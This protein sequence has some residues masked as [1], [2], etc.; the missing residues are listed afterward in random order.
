MSRKWLLLGVS[1]SI[2]LLATHCQADWPRFRGPNGSG[3]SADSQATPAKWSPEQNIKWKV[4]L[5]GSGVSSPIVVGDRVFVTCYSGYGV[6]RENLG[7]M[8][9]LKR[10]LVC[11]DRKSG[12]LLWDKS[13]KAVLPEDP[14]SGM[15][16]PSHGYASHTPVSD[17]E[18]VYVFFGK[19]GVLA[20]DMQGNQLWHKSVGTESD[21]KRW[22]SSSSPI[23]HE[24]LVIV[25]AS[26]ESRAIVGLNKKTGE[27][28]WRQ[29]TD[30][31]IDVWGTPLLVTVEDR[32]DLVIG[33]P[34]EFWGLNPTSGKTRW[35]SEAMNTDS[36]NSSVVEANGVIY[37]IEGR[38]GGSVAVKA[39]GK[40]DVT[41]T[42]V[43]WRGNDTARFGTPLVYGNRV[44]YFAS[45]VAN[46]IN[47]EDGTTIFKGRLPQSSGAAPRG[48]DGD[49][50]EQRR[51][52]GGGDDSDGGGFRGGSGGPG[53]GFRGGRGGRGFGSMDY[54]SPVAADGKIYY[55][56]SDGTVIVLNSG[57][58]FELLASNKT[59]NEREVFSSTPAISDGQ[60]FLRSDKHLYCVSE[61]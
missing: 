11:V 41:E 10:H 55:L 2:I 52:G 45:G 42:N 31:L 1:A 44:Y 33:V 61:N 57:D 4:K 40:G 12:D 27:E 8:E 34:Y 6:D 48:Q 25:T 60:I 24:D 13:V 37:G 18:N 38:G 39:G 36:Y 30:G 5:P 51:G 58:T 23:L 7:D 26:A 29:E 17:G 47:A 54:S 49:A 28:V 32:T 3:I 21:N 16:I 20:F 50:G 22:G 14:Y 53:G 35:Y 19:S 46:C 43:L 56:K 15:G 59:T 9:N